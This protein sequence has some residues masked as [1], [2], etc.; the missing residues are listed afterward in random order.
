MDQYNII[1]PQIGVLMRFDR[2][3]E[4]SLLA[5]SA[6]D[7]KLPLGEPLMYLEFPVYAP[8]AFSATQIFSY[9]SSLTRLSISPWK[10][11]SPIAPHRQRE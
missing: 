10:A 5:S 11:I 8:F 4:D 9:M 3:N 6:A 2:V 7:G 1:L